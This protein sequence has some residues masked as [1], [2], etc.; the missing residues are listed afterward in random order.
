MAV[1]AVALVAVELSCLYSEYYPVLTGRNQLVEANYHLDL[2]RFRDAEAS[3]AAA[4]KADPLSPEPVRLL[5]DLRMAQWRTTGDE[6]AWKAFV[7]E[8]DAYQRLDP[9]HHLAWYLRGN[10][11]LTAWRKSERPEDL[12]AAITAYRQ[13]SECYPNRALYHAQLAWALDLAGQKDAARQEAEK[14]L[15]LDGQMPHKE[16][17]L[18]RQHVA[19]PQVS[20]EPFKLFREETAEQT[21]QRLR[22]ASAEGKP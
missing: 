18:A 5:A 13:A 17:K 7:A 22:T 16:Q 8:A 6:E 14:A 3:A 20:S 9:R 2:K 11:F 15:D 10:W 21:A 19:D 4:A 12:D 1:V